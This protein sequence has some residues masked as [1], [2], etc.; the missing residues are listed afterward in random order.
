M[1]QDRLVY[2]NQARNAD[3]NSQVAM[4]VGFIILVASAVAEV[5]LVKTP[6]SRT[7]SAGV[8]AVGTVGTD[9]FAYISRMFNATRESALDGYASVSRQLELEDSFLSAERL[10]HETLSMTKSERVALIKKILEARLVAIR[11]FQ[12]DPNRIGAPA[13]HRRTLIA[14]RRAPRDWHVDP[15]SRPAIEGAGPRDD[16]QHD[17]EDGVS[18]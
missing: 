3:R 11:A 6:S 9:F 17:D 7:F 2:R 8:A 4:V 15:A 12:E 13:R 1:D 5:F 16:D 18:S 14:R 10:I